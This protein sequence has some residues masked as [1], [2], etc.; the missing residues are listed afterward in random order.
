MGRFELY[1]NFT[2]TPASIIIKIKKNIVKTQVAIY[3]SFTSEKRDQIKKYIL[4][5][6]GD[7]QKDVAKRASEAFNVSLDRKSVV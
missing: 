4:E 1:F 3:M 2:N 5:K 7:G 6:I